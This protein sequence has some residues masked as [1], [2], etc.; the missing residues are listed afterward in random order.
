MP[1]APVSMSAY[2]FAA[3]PAYLPQGRA[4]AHEARTVEIYKY[5]EGGRRGSITGNRYSMVRR[6]SSSMIVVIYALMLC[7]IFCCWRRG[8]ACARIRLAAT[9]C[10]R[11]ESG[12][13]IDIFLSLIPTEGQESTTRLS[14]GVYVDLFADLQGREDL[15]EGLFIFCCSFIVGGVFLQIVVDAR[16][17]APH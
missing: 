17:R 14:A 1:I 7:M 5:Q 11:S 8:T 16:K 4:G 12:A 15:L 9:W 10:A 2:P 3:G 13:S 6:L